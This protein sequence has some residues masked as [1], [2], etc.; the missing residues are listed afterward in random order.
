MSGMIELCQYIAAA[1][2]IIGSFLVTSQ[3][4]RRRLVA[5]WLYLAANLLM[6]TWA[7]VGGHWGVLACQAV[8]TVS[9]VVGIK[10]N[11]GV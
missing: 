6:G 11:Q 3:L 8:F 5:F 10:N 1:L 7:A 9:S 2:S 4:G